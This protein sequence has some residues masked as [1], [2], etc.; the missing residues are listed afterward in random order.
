MV[1]SVATALTA[2]GSA[3][4]GTARAAPS[5]QP[6]TTLAPTQPL[7]NA[8]VAMDARGDAVA[9]WDRVERVSDNGPFEYDV[10]AS[11]RAA[12]SDGWQQP[13]TL[14]TSSW[15]T[16][17]AVA[18]DGSGTATVVWN[19][20]PPDYAEGPRPLSSDRDARTGKWD[21]PVQ[22]APGPLYGSPQLGIDAAGDAVAAWEDGEVSYRPAGGGWQ[23]PAQPLNVSDTELA[24]G[25][26]GSMV[27]AGRRYDGQ[28]QV[29]TGYRGSWSGSTPLGTSTAYVAPAAAV[30]PG[31][32]AVVAW[33][34]AEHGNHI[35]YSAVRRSGAWLPASALS[36]IDGNAYEPAVGM[37]AAGDVLAIWDA[38]VDPESSFRPTGS[39]TWQRPVVA[40]PAI[41]YPSPTLAMN[42]AGDGVAVWVGLTT[43]ANG[44]IS[45]YPTG[46]GSYT[47]SGGWQAAQTLGSEGPHFDQEAA[48]AIDAAGDAIAVWPHDEGVDAN[49]NSLAT[50]QSAFLDNGGPLLHAAY[51]HLRP[52]ISGRARVGRKLRCTRGVWTGATPIR[53][54]F[55][56]LRGSRVAGHAQMYRV[57]RADA[58]RTLTCQVTATN[59]LG[60]VAATSPRVR[61]KG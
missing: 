47:A 6:V 39:S 53:F 19:H 10:L 11:Y 33:S 45:D 55:R 36:F 35:V 20:T 28:V 34:T 26:D 60:S 5:W 50:L 15:Y 56:W 52:R 49:Y 61:V 46:G 18:F 1:A 30:A 22:V 41:G 29:A 51:N 14:D 42:A 16:K 57:K 7:A 59:A 32:D 13:V 3:A 17:P 23:S 58:G 27:L 38:T 21:A 9:V 25:S 4:A 44:A 54:R 2:V 24:V 48:V 8:S 43:S 40:A 37:D 31:G 12:G